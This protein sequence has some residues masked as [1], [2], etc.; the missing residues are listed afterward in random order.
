MWLNRGYELV[1]G[2]REEPKEARTRKV[3][4][5]KMEVHMNSGALQWLCMLAYVP[6]TFLNGYDR[7]SYKTE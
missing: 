1:S 2:T 3:E 7:F 4:V 6:R 5:G